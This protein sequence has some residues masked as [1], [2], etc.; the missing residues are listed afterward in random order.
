[1]AHGRKPCLSIQL[2]F[3][4]FLSWQAYADVYMH[5]PRGSNNRLNE[6]SKPRRNN[7]RLFDSQVSLS[8]VVKQDFCKLGIV[9]GTSVSLRKNC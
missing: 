4:H 6:D 5:N 2:L 8:P 3:L 7:N 1:M 9:I